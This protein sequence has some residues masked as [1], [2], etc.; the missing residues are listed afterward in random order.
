MSGQH[1]APDGALPRE[2][3]LAEWYASQYREAVGLDGAEGGVRFRRFTG[4]FP[5]Q[6]PKAGFPASGRQRMSNF[7]KLKIRYPLSPKGYACLVMNATLAAGGKSHYSYA[8][9]RLESDSAGPEYI[10][11]S[12][13]FESRDGE[14]R[15]R[16]IRGEDFL[17]ASEE[18]SSKLAPFEE[19]VL[20]MLARGEVRLDS[21]VFPE[22]AAGVITERATNLRLPIVAFAV[23]L[24]LDLWEASAGFLSMVHTSPG[25]IKVIAGVAAAWPSLAEKSRALAA[26]PEIEALAWGAAAARALLEVKCGQKLVPLHL[27]EVMQVGDFNLAGW[28]ELAV[29]RL[30]GDLVINFVAPGF[31]IYG[32]WSY[33]EGADDGLFENKAMKGR[34]A[35][36]HAAEVASRSL[37]EARKV[38]RDEAERNWFASEFSGHVYES[39]EYAQSFLVMSKVALLHTM[40]DVGWTLLSLPRNVR[41]SLRQWPAATGAFSDPDTAARHIFEYVY[42]AH[43]LHDKVGIA[44]TDLHGN[45]L[46][47][48]MWGTNDRQAEVGDQRTEPPYYQD[49]VVAFVTGP[50]GEAD[51]YIFP[52]AGDSGCIIDFSRCILG[53]GFRPRLEEGRPPQY[54][55]H[56]YR[57]Q[58]GRVLRA[59]ARYAPD[60]VTRHQDAIKAAVLAKFEA[61]FPVLCAV[62]F[63]AIGSTVGEMLAEQATHVDEEE[64]RPFQVA[65]EAI[66]LARR[67]EDASR[68]VLIEGL[69]RLVSGGPAAPLPGRALLE[70]VFGEWQFARWAAREPGRVR[71]TQLVDAYNFNNELRYSGS[72]Y[73]KYPPWGRLD[74]IERHLGEYRL[75]DLFG[76]GVEP[77]L[78]ALHPGARVEVLA[79]QVRAA[80]EKLD[81]PPVSTGS[82]WLGD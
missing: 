14:Y 18:A 8:Y 23:A 21:Q 26:D 58:A 16:F 63:L 37:R 11:T 49:P 34:Y 72:D 20:A 78:E 56:F 27:R 35:T 9:W 64:V 65:A 50:R 42:G 32:Q 71:T 41:R 39:I 29:T 46:T 82:S 70:K 1:Q 69:H 67:L 66:G 24:A 59:L 54:A 62:D 31:P 12:P 47:F 53:P 61:V 81:G 10:C 79:E 15:R 75:A 52:A 57:D 44:H 77:F 80:Q 25:Y 30:V 76:R 17:G 3:D 33:L 19:A 7:L 45:N 55:A 5:A 36:S 60:Y 2:N 43:C 6:A 48:F 68:A 13:T 74:E 73:A 4:T 51:T 38:V 22:E 40:E 28:R